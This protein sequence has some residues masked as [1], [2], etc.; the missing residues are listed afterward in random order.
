MIL[1]GDVF[2]RYR[3]PMALS[4]L[5]LLI[6]CGLAG[7]L[8]YLR[9][10][11]TH[12]ST[13]DAFVTGR[14]HSIASKVPGTVTRIAVIDNQFV[15]QGEVLAEIDE[16]DYD[17]RV[18]ETE[19]AVRAEKAKEREISLRGD[20][21]RRQLEEAGYRL[22]SA[23]ANLR[24]QEVQTRQT[25]IDLKR[26]IQ[27]REKKIIAEERYDRTRTAFDTAR[28]QVEAARE[29]VK[30]AEAAVETQRS[31]IRQ[32]ESARQSQEATVRQKEESLQADLLRKSYTKIV[33]P[34]DGYVTKRSVEVGNQIQ[35]G[36][37]LM[38]VVALDS[39][40]IVANYKETQLERMKPGQKAEVRVDG[41][42]G[43]TF[44]GRVDSI[45]A[46]T[47]AVF[48]LFPPE[49]ATGNYVKV[50][51]RIPVKILLDRGTDP[52]HMLRVGMSVVPTILVE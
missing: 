4:L 10:R 23:R 24:L 8:Y 37:P 40:W 25:E 3:R 5:A 48:S 21:A 38:A 45:M 20:V 35:A 16:R 11:S 18:R 39:V 47:G 14:I 2:L 26:A 6:L 44:T 27:L 43:R 30:Q 32:M 51:Q 7:F 15:K 50:V 36:Q 19:S 34:A 22:E 29:Q 33:A 42:P 46:G 49:N 9:Y 52:G 13:D 12:V 28:A 17:V 1:K 31:L 41:Y